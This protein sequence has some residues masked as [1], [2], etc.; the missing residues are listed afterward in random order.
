MGMAEHDWTSLDMTRHESPTDKF[1]DMVLMK[2][3]IN[4]LNKTVKVK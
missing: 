3:E 4:T 2:S 1:E